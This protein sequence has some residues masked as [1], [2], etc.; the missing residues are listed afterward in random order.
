MDIKQLILDKLKET[1]LSGEQMS[2]WTDVLDNLQDSSLDDILNFINSDERAIRILTDSLMAK[3]T[4]LQNTDLDAW[5]QAIK[6]DYE[7]ANSL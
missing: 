3:E 2:L 4:A 1:Q 7:A 5:A 6:S